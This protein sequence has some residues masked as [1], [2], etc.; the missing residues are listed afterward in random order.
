MVRTSFFDSLDFEP[1]EEECH[2]LHA[3]EVAAAVS[4]ALELRAGA[5]VEEV[6]IAPLKKVVRHRRGAQ[7][8]ATEAKE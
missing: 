5:V 3:E 2:A 8:D 1:G 7:K 6:R 4:L